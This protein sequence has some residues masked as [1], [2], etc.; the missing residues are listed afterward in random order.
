MVTK[1]QKLTEIPGL[2]YSFLSDF[3][4]ILIGHYIFQPNY[5]NFIFKIVADLQRDHNYTKRRE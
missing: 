1:Q 4:V 2:G 3:K 5:E